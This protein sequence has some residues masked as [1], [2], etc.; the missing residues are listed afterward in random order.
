MMKILAIDPGNIESAF[1]LLN[2]DYTISN[3]NFFKFGNDNVLGTIQSLGGIY[4]DQLTV[5]IEKVASYGMAVGAEVFDTCIWIGRFTE[6]AIE[7]GC[8]VEYVYRMDEK[9]ALC[10]DSRAKDANIRQTLGDVFADSYPVWYICCEKCLSNL[11]IRIKKASFE[12]QQK[13]LNR[14]CREWNA[15]WTADSQIER[16]IFVKMEESKQ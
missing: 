12:E 6:A 1:V 16:L 9:M 3:G 5:V 7:R 15:Q 13:A 11:R 4:G 14:L 10:H 2:P 8:Q